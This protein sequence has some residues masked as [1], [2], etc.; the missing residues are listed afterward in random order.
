M[1]SVVNVLVCATLCCLRFTVKISRALCENSCGI[2]FEVYSLFIVTES[3]P[4]YVA[5]EAKPTKLK[6]C[7]GCK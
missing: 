7:N 1:D 5:V 3:R 2:I 4:I 6:L